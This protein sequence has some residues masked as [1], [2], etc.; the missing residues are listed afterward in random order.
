MCPHFLVIVFW[1]FLTEAHYRFLFSQRD[2]SPVSHETGLVIVCVLDLCGFSYRRTALFISPLARRFLAEVLQP[3]LIVHPISHDLVPPNDL[4]D[5]LLLSFEPVFVPL[6]AS[7]A[8]FSWLILFSFWD[9]GSSSLC[10]V[11]CWNTERLLSCS[12]VDS[13]EKGSI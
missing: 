1:E 8:T 9:F 12:S 11:T 5:G 4:H 7:N 2:P 13:D 3:R 10:I 6:V